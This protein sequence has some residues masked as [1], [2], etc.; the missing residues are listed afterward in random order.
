MVY[1]FIVC[2]LLDLCFVCLYKKP[3]LHFAVASGLRSIG[4]PDEQPAPLW[5]WSIQK[6]FSDLTFLANK[7]PSLILTNKKTHR[8]WQLKNLCDLANKQT[9]WHFLFQASISYDG[10]CHIFIPHVEN[11]CNVSRLP[12]LSWGWA[13]TARISETD[14]PATWKFIFATW[15]FIFALESLHLPLESSHSHLKFIFATSHFHF[16]SRWKISVATLDW[17]NTEIHPHATSIHFVTT[18]LRSPCFCRKNFSE[19]LARHLGFFSGIFSGIRFS[20]IGETFTFSTCRPIN[21]KAFLGWDSSKTNICHVL[22]GGV[23]GQHIFTVLQSFKESSQY[24]VAIL[25]KIDKRWKY[26][27]L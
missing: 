2:L 17:N 6:T 20:G 14:C 18:Y 27:G 21:A 23:K 25:W 13:G 15:K 10:D 16:T 11:F 22:V 26:F 3:E 1:T 5:F 9:L 19:W 4:V 12:V 7:K 8:F 24:I